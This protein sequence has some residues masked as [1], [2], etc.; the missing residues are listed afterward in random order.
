MDGLDPSLD[1]KIIEKVGSEKASELSIYYPDDNPVELPD[2]LEFNELSI[3]KMYTSI[4]GPFLS[5]DMEGGGRGSNA[6]TVSASNSST[7][8]PILCNDTHLI[9]STPGVWY[10]NHL[11]SSE[12]IHVTGASLPGLNGI[13]IGHN[14]KLHGE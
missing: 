14:E 8:R 10:L 11:Y 5:K 12:G 4:K 1:K 2:G 6:W 13:L 7:G 3:D 9:L